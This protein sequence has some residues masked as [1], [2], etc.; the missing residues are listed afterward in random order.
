[1]GTAASVAPGA[2]TGNTSTITVTPAGGFTGSV[3]LTAAITSS[4]AGAQ[5]PPSLSFGSTSP[6]SIT[7]T[8]AGT[9]TLTINTMAPSSAS[10]LLP[11]RPGGSW[12]VA[13]SA[14]LACL[15]LFGIPG[16]RRRWRTMLGML[17]FLV[18]LTGSVLA[19]G[20]GGGGSGGGGR[21]GGGSSNP[22]TT[23]G[24]YTV[25]V[26]GTSGTITQTGTV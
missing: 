8:T 5:Y 6:V 26:T 22:G 2:T 24:T 21:G 4:P 25:T 3:S 10:L 7:G 19:C 15:L 1:S 17:L 11:K 16:R 12:Y 9:A 18:A 23:A 14:T 20:G 13:G